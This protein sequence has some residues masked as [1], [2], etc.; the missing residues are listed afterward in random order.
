[1]NKALTYLK[2]KVFKS[3]YSFLKLGINHGEIFKN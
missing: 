3:F 2:R 1:M